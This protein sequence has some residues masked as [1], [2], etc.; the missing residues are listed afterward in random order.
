MGA[1][2]P[3]PAGAGG[4]PA[5]TDGPGRLVGHL[6]DQ[7][8]ACGRLGSPLYARLLRGLAVDLQERGATAEVLAGHEEA[9]RDDLVALRLLGGVHHLVLTGRA[10]RLARQYPSVG[11]TPDDDL[12]P[13][14]L[15]VVRE[16][17]EDVRPWSGSPPQTNEAGRS[18]ALVGGLLL[19][20]DGRDLPVR[21]YETGA[22]AGLGLHGDRF[23]HQVAADGRWWGPDTSPVELEDAWH[24]AAPDPAAPLRVVERHGSDVAPVDLTAPGAPDRL[25]AWVWPDQ[26]ARVARLRAALEVAAAHPLPVARLGAADAVRAMTL[27]PGH[28]TVLW[29]SIMW[30]YVPAAEQAGA[31]DALAA[32]GATATDDA[33]LVRLSLEPAAAGDGPAGAF[34]VAATV[35]PGGARRLLGHASAHG[36]PVTW[37]G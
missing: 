3:D 24:G 19:L 33:P 17:A 1:A 20:L 27:M 9:A 12:V 2:V 16:H 21:L 30:Q 32:L 6:L 31:E 26:T 11:G 36:P 23:R 25:L 34:V 10:P 28:L 22:S 37:L 29:H 14:F 7:A 4:A 8:E 15:A 13:A 35:W 5:G 18:T